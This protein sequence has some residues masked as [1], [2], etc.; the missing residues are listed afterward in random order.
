MPKVSPSFPVERFSLDNGLRVVVSP[1]R[2]SPTVDV[3]I[4]YDVGMR[5]EPKGRTGFAHLFEHFMFQGSKNLPKGEFDRH[6]ESN[7]GVNNGFT[8]ADQTVY[9]E[10][11]PSNA[12]EVALYLEADR[13]RG[14]DLT[15]ESLHN[16]IDV[17]KEEIRVNV[18]NAPYGG[19]PWEFLPGVMF[20]SFANAHDGYGSFEDLEAATI[21][22][23]ID[24]FDKYYAP[25][26]AFLAVTGDTTT[27]DVHKLVERHFADIP[28]R[29]VPPLGD[30]SEPLPDAQRVK[31]HEDANAPRPAL[32]LGYRVPDP[33]TDLGGAAA[34]VVLAS[35][36]ADGDAARLYQRLVKTDRTATHVQAYVGEFGDAFGSRDPTM[37]QI[38][39]YYLDGAAK[40]RVVTAIDEEIAKV[41]DRVEPAEVERSVNAM[42]AE[43]LAHVDQIIGR[44][45]DLV[46][47]EQIRGA[48]EFIND[49]PSVLGTVTAE[50][51]AEAA[52]TWLRSDRRALLDWRP[53]ANA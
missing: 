19:F 13:L 21:D 17:V 14:L 34:T 40:D 6:I 20:E 43:Y 12:L 33:R 11:L 1:D 30:F 32:A 48:A 36:L 25:G 35:V 23:A 9:Y 24:F 8:R 29:P 38:V 52:G 10:V 44:T 45:E 28:G 41:T 47:L 42:T 31:V 49:V 39:V 51:V 4:A 18:L 27:E 37:L 22:D 15:E 5:S 7:G 50:H 46:T 16:Q 3:T 53:G 26:N 2:S